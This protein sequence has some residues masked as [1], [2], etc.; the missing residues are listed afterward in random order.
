MLAMVEASHDKSTSVG[1]TEVTIKFWGTEGGLLSAAAVCEKLISDAKNRLKTAM[2][3]VDLK[4][5]KFFIFS[6][7]KFNF[8]VYIFLTM[9]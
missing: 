3:D 7:F 9:R 1:E 6:P 8:I 4:S 5:L 2:S